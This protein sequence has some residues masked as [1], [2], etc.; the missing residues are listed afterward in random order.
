[1]GLGRFGSVFKPKEIMAWNFLIVAGILEVG[2]ATGL[3]Y[4]EG[5]TRLWPSVATMATM[6]LKAD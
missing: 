2:W 5:F 3:K 6:T 4:T 1:M